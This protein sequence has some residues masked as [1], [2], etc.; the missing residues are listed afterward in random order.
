LSFPLQPDP[1]TWAAGQNITAPGLRADPANLVAL[2]ARRPLLVAAQLTAAQAI[3]ESTVV[4]VSLD[5]EYADNWN[6]HTIP[7]ATY[8]A[9]LA[10]IYLAEGNVFITGT[11]TSGSYGAGIEVV[12]G[13]HTHDHLGGYLCGNGVNNTGPAASDL[14]E[15][16]PY[17]SDTVCLYAE[18]FATAS[19]ALATPGAYFSVRWAGLG[20]NFSA[21]QGAV[22]GTVVTSPQPAALWPPGSGTLITN[23]GGIAAGATSM[24][25]LSATGIIVGSTLGLDYYEGQPVSPVAESVT[26]S[27]VTGTTIGISATSYPHGGNLTPG[28]VAVPVSAAWM[29]Q[30][31]RDVIN[32][33]A[34][35]PMCRLDNISTTQALGSQ[36]F[37]AGTA[38]TWTGAPIDNFGGWNS[39][40]SYVFPVSGVYYIYGQVFAEA[41]TANLSAGYAISGGTVHW[42]DSIRSQV[43]L[44]V[45]AIVRKAAVRVTAGQYVQLFGS[46]NSGGAVGLQGSGA[47]YSTL[48]CLWTGF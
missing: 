6:G 3:A 21:G 28:Y 42:G 7:A 11:S 22:N 48:L 26:V 10:G 43:S 33:L 47:A 12:Q 37:P 19:T 39:G 9:P 2:L 27:S 20:V 14:V 16:N 29:N 32:F 13:G 44:S 38:I 40:Q 35:P 34:F 31:V 23:S 30:Q 15:L 36:T 4:P 5:A 18:Q 25:V 41:M 17:T 8:A 46:Q 24:T 1:V 45:C